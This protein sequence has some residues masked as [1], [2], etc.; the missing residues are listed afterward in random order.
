MSV[1][2]RP[3]RSDDDIAQVTRLAWDFVGLLR[4][5]YPERQAQL[6]AYLRDQRFAAMLANLR[7]HFNPPHGECLLAFHDDAAVGIVMLKPVDKRLCE[8]NRMYVSPEAR[9]LGIGRALCTHLIAAARG[10]GYAEMRL[11]A[12][13][14]HV[15]ALPL[16]RSLGFRPDPEPPDFGRDDPGIVHLRLDLGQG[17]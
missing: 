4:D 5:R 17:A 8:M 13:H 9:G 11:G 6:D 3:A 16:Y 7:D 12:L 14:R 15:E 1:E 10:L 2:I